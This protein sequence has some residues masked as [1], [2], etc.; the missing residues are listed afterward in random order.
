MIRRVITT[1]TRV[2]ADG[3]GRL[4]AAPAARNL[5]PI[6][7]VLLPRLP[8]RGDVL[9]LASGTGQHIAALAA[10]RPDLSFHPTDP[11]P[12]R[13][14]SID[15]HCRG[16]PNVMPAGDIDA[17]Q[18]GWAVEAGADAVLVVNLLHLISDGELAILLDEAHRAMSPGG[19]LAIYGPF[20]RDGILSSPG[21]RAFDA[22]LRAQDE[23]IGLKDAAM[24]E[25]VLTVLGCAVEM[26]EMPA[27]NL[28]ILA[29]K[30]A[31]SAL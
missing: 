20:R 9:E 29:Q 22:D 27:N 28:M 21:D 13:R 5:G 23:A 30:D 24:I 26:V 2:E 11:D 17:G 16:L 25:T 19:L 15:A 3:D 8:R 18:A 31:G 1:G 7:D 14:A 12:T 6:L 4:I 10:H